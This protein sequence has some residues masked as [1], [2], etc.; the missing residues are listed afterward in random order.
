MS[1]NTTT[2]PPD[3]VDVRGPRFAAWVTT[4]VIVATLIAAAVSP[5]A[6]A[7]I[8]VSR[9]SCS[10]SVRGAGPVTIRMA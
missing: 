5:V 1:T 10:R 3:Q 7:V 6:A 2:A 4:V 8:L 9:P